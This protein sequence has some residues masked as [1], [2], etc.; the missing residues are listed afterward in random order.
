MSDT[1]IGT[2]TF[3]ATFVEPMECEIVSKLREGSEWVYG[4]GR[5]TSARRNERA[6]K[7]MTILYHADG[8]EDENFQRL[9]KGQTTITAKG[10]PILIGV[11]R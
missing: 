10:N 6:G 5:Q 3:T 8:H 7:A 1:R 4:S 11:I 9:V 2:S